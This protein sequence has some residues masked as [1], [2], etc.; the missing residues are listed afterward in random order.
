MTNRI[1]REAASVRTLVKTRYP[2]PHTLVESAY[3]LAVSLHTRARHIL[4]PQTPEE[5]AAAAD[6]LLRGVH[7]DPTPPTQAS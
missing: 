4:R 1:R 3:W 7:D 2:A 6:E 5:Q